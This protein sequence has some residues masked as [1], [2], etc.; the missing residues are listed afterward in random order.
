MEQPTASRRQALTGVAGLAAAAAIVAPK[1][2]SAAVPPSGVDAI[3]EL[4]PQ[5]KK[6][7]LAEILSR[8]G[9]SL[10]QPEQVAL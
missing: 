3:P 1:L 6:L 2:A 10:G 5:W 4:A 8:P 9:L 7:D